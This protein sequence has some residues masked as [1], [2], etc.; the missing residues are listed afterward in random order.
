MGDLWSKSDKAV[1]SQTMLHSPELI[2]VV[3]LGEE[4]AVLK[5]SN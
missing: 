4:R 3:Q 1:I 5:V 2:L